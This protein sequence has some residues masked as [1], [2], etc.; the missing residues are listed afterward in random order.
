MPRYACPYGD[1]I[2]LGKMTKCILAPDPSSP[3]PNYELAALGTIPWY[4]INGM[5]RSTARRRTQTKTFGE[6]LQSLALY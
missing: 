5:L 4:L 2:P 3:E 6:G 1:S